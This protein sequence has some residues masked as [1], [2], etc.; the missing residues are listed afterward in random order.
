MQ[1]LKTTASP[2]SESTIG[3]APRSERSMIAQPAMARAMPPCAQAPEPSGP[4]GA[5]ASAIR[6][7]QAR[8]R[9]GRRTTAPRRSRTRLRS[10]AT[11][12]RRTPRSRPRSRR[13][14]HERGE[15]R[16]VRR[17]VTSDSACHCT[18]SAKC[19]ASV[20]TASM[21]PS[22]DQATACS[23]VPTRSHRLVVEGVDVEPL[24]AEQRA[25]G[26]WRARRARRA[27]QSAPGRV[28]R[29]RPT[30]DFDR[31]GAGAASLRATR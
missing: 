31:A 1:P 21:T 8:R 2:S 11:A 16:R 29:W 7:D 10:P 5:S 6:V 28:W 18:P 25:P 14:A 13:R 22:G 19:W 24:A 20:S 9:P 27:S 15:Q 3:C 30:V 26:G 4:R 23:P 17:V 12:R